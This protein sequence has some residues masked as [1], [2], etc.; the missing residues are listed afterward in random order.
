MVKSFSI[1]KI[2]LKLELL[3]KMRLYVFLNGFVVNNL[4]M[5]RVVIVTRLSFPDK[6]HAVVPLFIVNRFVFKRP[7][8]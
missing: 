3:S 1:S 8:L 5:I 4:V 6:G 7:A 2:L